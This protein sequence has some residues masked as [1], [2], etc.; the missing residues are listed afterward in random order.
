MEE[1]FMLTIQFQEIREKT[2][3]RVRTTEE[4]SSRV[5][6][7]GDFKEATEEDK[8]RTQTSKERL[9]IFNKVLIIYILY[10][11]FLI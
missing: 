11:Y 6:T 1:R 3:V 9:L 10:F 8:V 2:K 5:E 7:E 4:V